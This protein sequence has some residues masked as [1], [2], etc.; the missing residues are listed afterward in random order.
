MKA[1][2]ILELSEEEL[3]SKEAELKEQLF[4]LKFQHALGQLENTMKL[5]NIKLDIARIKTVLREKSQGM[6]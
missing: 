5:K 6:E 3:K 1:R 4:K 2:E